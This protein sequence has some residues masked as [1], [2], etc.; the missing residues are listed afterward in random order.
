VRLLAATDPEGSAYDDWTV[1][2]LER[3]RVPEDANA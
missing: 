2:A 3:P 1:T